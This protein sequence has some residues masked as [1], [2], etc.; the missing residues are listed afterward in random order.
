MTFSPEIAVTTLKQ[1][2]WWIRIYRWPCSLFVGL[3]I[4]S[5]AAGSFLLW[6]CKLEAY[7]EPLGMKLFLLGWILIIGSSFGSG[8]EKHLALPA[9]SVF[10]TRF[11][12]LVLAAGF[13]LNLVAW[14]G[15]EQPP[16]NRGEQN[17]AGQPATRLESK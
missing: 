7:L 14:I 4:G 2:S 16:E 3:L 15:L 6:D 5:L 11:R 10:E 8:R 17:A 9:P 13:I 1:D 12:R